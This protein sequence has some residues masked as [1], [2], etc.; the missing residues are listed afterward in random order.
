MASA[1]SI[2]SPRP[3]PNKPRQLFSATCL[4]CDTLEISSSQAF[5]SELLRELRPH[6]GS[7]FFKPVRDRI[8]P[9]VIWG[10]HL[11]I[12]QPDREAIRILDRYMRDANHRVSV[13]RAHI[14]LDIDI[15]PGVTREEAIEFIRT[16]FHLRYRRDSDEEFEY[17]G[18]RYSVRVKGRK[19]RPAKQTAFYFDQMGRLDGECEKLHYE[20]RLEKTRAVKAAGIEYPADLF[21]LDPHQFVKQQLKIADHKPI[22]EKITQRYVN[23]MIRDTPNPHCDIAK[24]VPESLRRM[25]T[26]TLTGFK[27]EFPRQFE[28]L[29]SWP[30]ETLNIGNALEWVGGNVGEL[31]PLS[32]T[33]RK[34]QRIRL[35]IADHEGE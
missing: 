8:D 5:R 7:L 20:I 34:R 17:F 30:L 11:K 18:T 2:I 21:A 24:R 25:G 12:N 16:A 31:S 33:P 15:P 19:T 35:R 9:N 23:N 26:D 14:A 32:P 1:M 4:Y 27:R 13:C 3:D 29:A 6:C 28:R 10:H 22:L